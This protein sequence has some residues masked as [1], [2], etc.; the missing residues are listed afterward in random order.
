MEAKSL[1]AIYPGRFD[2]PALIFI[3][4]V[5]L[6]VG[7][8]LPVLT[9]RQLFSSNS[10]S[11][12]SGVRGL[13]NDKQILL[14][15]I[16]FFF[17]VVFPFVKLAALLYL[18]LFELPDKIRKKILYWLLVLGKWSM[19]DV[20]VVAVIVVA[21]KMGLVAKARPQPGIYVFGLSIFI[22]MIASSLVNHLAKKTHNP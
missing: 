13:I 19:L 16:I 3:S 11:V 4:L 1:R 2:V 15:F 9:V 7:L 18:W 14:A 12:I 10:F 20:F 22:S 21:V 17:S 6:I 5:L 8:N